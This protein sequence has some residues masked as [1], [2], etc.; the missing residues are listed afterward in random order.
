MIKPVYIFVT[1]YFPRPESWTGGFCYDF[2]RALKRIGGYDVR[3]FVNDKSRRHCGKDY[4]YHGIK[5]C[6]F[7]YRRLPFNIAPFL[8]E[9]SNRKSFLDKVASMGI[10]WKNVA[11]FHAHDIHMAPLVES[12]KRKFPQIVSVWHCHN[13]GHPFHLSCGRLGVI[14]GYS[15][16]YYFWL[17]KHFERI[18]LPVFVS[19]RQRDMFGKWYPEGFLGASVDVVKG[20]WGGKFIRSVELKSS[21]VCYNGIDYSVFNAKGRDDRHDAA[22]FRIGFVANMVATK[23]PMTLLRAV[24][25]LKID[26]ELNGLQGWE[27]IFVGSG[28]EL[29][30]CRR[31]VEENGLDRIVRFRTEMD[32]LELPDFYRSL[33]LFVSPSWAEGFCCTFVEAHGCGVPI[34]GCTGVSVDE[35]FSK[36][37]Q[38]RWLFPPKDDAT[39]AQK[40]KWFYQKRPRQTFIDRFDIDEIVGDF[41]KKIESIS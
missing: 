4:E 10:D 6:R 31:Y 8:F 21:Y 28:A 32:H 29:P 23:D 22:V 41:V 33:D 35:C 12:V 34:I 13:M 38:D 24:N 20:L 3:V 36:D 1:P 30:R 7:V 37:E 40:I 18:D 39:L 15:T 25:R 26:P 17:R 14:P 5:V 2:V 19:R 27:C 11:V 16:L 9:G